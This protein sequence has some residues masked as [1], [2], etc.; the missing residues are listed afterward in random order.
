MDVDLNVVITGTVDPRAG[1]AGVDGGGVSLQAQKVEVELQGQA[2]LPASGQTTIPEGSSTG[3]VIFVNVTAYAVNVPAG[4]RIAVAGGGIAFHTT[5]DVWVPASDFRGADAYLGK[6]QVN[7]V[8]DTPGSAGN[9]E[10]ST[11]SVIV[12]DLNG[13]LTVEN[14]EATSGG[15]ERQTSVVTTEDQELLRQ[16]LVQGLRSDAYNQLQ[17]KLGTLQVLS[18]TLSVETL[19]EN[20][21]QGVGSEAQTL[22]LRARVRASALACAPSALD[23]AVAAAVL[24]QAPAGKGQEVGEF[25]PTTIVVN[26]GPGVNSL[27]YQVQG[28]VPI[29]N[30]IDDS[31]RSEIAGKLRG[32]TYAEVQKIMAGYQDRIASFTFS[33][34]VTRLPSIGG[35]RVEAVSTAK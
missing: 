34:A 18:G 20:F 14:A 9:V 7:I 24:E 3:A 17:A 1:V 2:F 21:S 29:R 10:A 6:A 25:E 30:K 11:I 35:L 16:Q 28:R 33:P 15:S 19:E 32:K 13:V 12:G 8:A 27:T 26:S 5:Q 4:T 23:Q 22:T 31:L